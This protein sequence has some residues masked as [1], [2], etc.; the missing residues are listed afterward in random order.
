MIENTISRL[1]MPAI[2]SFMGLALTHAW[3]LKTLGPTKNAVVIG[4]AL[5]ILASKNDVIERRPA[6][7]IIWESLGPGEQLYG[8]EAVRTGSKASGKITFLKSGMSIGLEPDSLVIIEQTDGKLQLNLVNGGVFVKSES[9][10]GSQ[11]NPG[12]QTQPIL[13]A[14][15][16]KIEL[17]GKSSE[18]N[19]SVSES[20]M[21][22]VQVTKGGAKIGGSGGMTETLKEGSSQLI[23]TNAAAPAVLEL[24][25]PRSGSSIPISSINESLSLSWTKAP[26][27][28]TAFI[29]TGST[30]DSMTRLP[31][32][33]PASV[34]KIALPIRPGDFFWRMI[35]VKDGKIVAM[36]PTTFNQGV[37][38]DPPK[39][40]T[41]AENDKIAISSDN[42]N[43]QVHLSWTRPSGA[44]EVTVSVAKDPEFQNTVAT[45]TFLTESEWMVLVKDAGK[46]FWRTSV[47]WPGI[48]RRVFSKSG[49]FEVVQQKNIPAPVT[50]S[51]ASGS[52]I[53]KNISD[54]SGIV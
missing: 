49:G 33:V 16:K 28:S 5:A 35:A 29:E 24:S 30:R 14:G 43:L 2:I 44:E 37:T 15:N 20:G 25:G 13:K 11:N 19:L 52:L 26:E 12:R 23:S 41:H 51:P 27:G 10:S 32:G 22:N 48:D 3:Y 4:D 21:T 39:L 8:G 1:T 7:R 46:Y 9:T 53:P 40:L 6:T 18:L 47:K 50:K 45:K 42:K 31:Q 38:L 34:G 54:G 36:G 17:A